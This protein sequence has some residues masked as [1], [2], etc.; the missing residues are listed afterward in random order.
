MTTEDDFQRAL[1]ACPEDWQTRLV[2][3]DWLDERGDP[4]GPGYRALGA[5]EMHP[6]RLDSRW[7]YL[8]ASLRLP[9]AQWMP[10][11]WYE[12]MGDD[13]TTARRA[14]EDLAARAFAKLPAE[15]R[16][17]LLAVAP[18]VAP[19]PEPAGGWPCEQ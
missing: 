2:F 6:M 17:E 10:H 16:A 15:R 9:G 3:A 18:A 7:L 4:R 1:D 19:N 8:R 14:A 12:L 11:D 13:V 5:N